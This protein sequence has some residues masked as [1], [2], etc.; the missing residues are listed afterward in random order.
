VSSIVDSFTANRDA[1]ANQPW[2]TGCRFQMYFILKR[3]F[4]IALALLTV[5]ISDVKILVILDHCFSITKRFF[6]GTLGYSRCKFTIHHSRC[7]V[8]KCLFGKMLFGKKLNLPEPNPLRNTN[9]NPHH[10]FL[11]VTKLSP[12]Q[13]IY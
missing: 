2:M 10:S 3:I 5:N 4:W 6:C 8:K 7:R 1:C 13:Q 12:Y 9:N 11:L